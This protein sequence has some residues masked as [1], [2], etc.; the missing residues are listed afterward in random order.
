MDETTYFEIAVNTFYVGMY[1]T[2]VGEALL[3][4]CVFLPFQDTLLSWGR[5]RFYQDFNGTPR[6][7]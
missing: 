2:R 1:N 7:L 5:K 6:M 4:N 3:N